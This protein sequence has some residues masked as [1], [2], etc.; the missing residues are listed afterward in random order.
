MPGIAWW[1]LLAAIALAL[2]LDHRVNSTVERA[3]V[4]IKGQIDRIQHLLNEILR[5]LPDAGSEDSIEHRLDRTEAKLDRAEANV[6]RILDT[7]EEV[8]R[9]QTSLSL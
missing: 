6:R 3:A 9:E 1:M 5:R 7:L 4:G 2:W 8:Q